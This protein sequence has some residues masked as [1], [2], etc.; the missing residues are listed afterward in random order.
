MKYQALMA[1]TR[2]VGLLAL[3][4][5]LA[6]GAGE[7][8]PGFALIPAGEFEMGDHHGFVDPKHGGDETP[9]HPVKV[10]AFQMGIYDVTTREYVA[11]LQAA[12]T[13]KQIEVREGGVYLV[14]GKEL[15]C[16]TRALSPYSRIGWDGRAF[17][18][19][20]G[21]ENH[22]V[23]C[24]RWAGAAL[25]C[26]GLSGQQKRPLCYD[27]ATWA[28]DFNQSG[29]RLPT[30]AEWEYAARGGLKDPYRNFPWGDEA[31]PLKANWPE[32]KNP[33]HSGPLPWTTPVGFFD[34]SLRRKADYGWPGAEEEFQTA[35]GANGYGLYDMSGNVWQFVNDWYGR[36][37]YAYS[38]AADPPG[39]E[40]G[41]VMPDGKPYRGMRG[42]NWY[43]GENGHGRVSNR[44]PSYFRGPQDPDHPYYHLGFR[45]VLPV[46]AESR[47]VIKPTPVQKVE[48]GAGA[49]PGGRPP[50][51]ST[52]PGG[53][54]GEGGRE[55][56]PAADQ[57][58]AR[59]ANQ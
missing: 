26:N 37:Y 33:F 15:L 30:E 49:L 27:P 1:A 39:P 16:E 9:L 20:D 51:G 44:N 35:K 38:P 2:S 23:V 5:G 42:G 22:P 19:L 52:R 58:Q 29:F 25:Y 50:R 18:V 13:Q 40:S 24:I 46:D 59:D 48:R 56:P 21:K 55:P 34:G 4:A 36:D 57:R 11:F 43:N 6:A 31:D 7:A 8:L 47:P 10:G 41:S 45:V 3:A 28:C 53:R 14:G 17:T 12:A 32:S 54:R